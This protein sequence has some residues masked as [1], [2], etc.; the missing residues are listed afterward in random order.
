MQISLLFAAHESILI[1][2]LSLFGSLG[3]DGTSGVSTQTSGIRMKDSIL[4]IINNQK[5]ASEA[6]ELLVWDWKGEANHVLRHATPPTCL[7]Q[8][9]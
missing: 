7:G 2:D 3:D 4:R 8:S 5:R 9:S 1:S 6:S